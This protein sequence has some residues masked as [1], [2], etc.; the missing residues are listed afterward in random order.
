M[1]IQIFC[2]L[3]HG[4][5]NHIFR[6]QWWTD[7]K[8][9]VDHPA[10][11]KLN[12]T[13]NRPRHL[14]F[15]VHAVAHLELMTEVYK[16]SLYYFR[17]LHIFTFFMCIFFSFRINNLCRCPIHLI[18]GIAAKAEKYGG[19]CVLQVMFCFKESLEI[20]NCYIN[21]LRSKTL[22]HVCPCRW[23]CPYNN[24]SNPLCR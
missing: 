8:S 21:F 4:Y 11:L 23:F 13:M 1:W 17:S 15:S 6:I 9:I 22:N 2:S 16:Y 7:F 24:I 12:L 18:F 20:L 19:Q 10:S 3:N 5:T 14:S